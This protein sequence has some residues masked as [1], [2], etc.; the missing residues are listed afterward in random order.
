[1]CM[2]WLL[3]ILNF[4]KFRVPE[5][6]SGIHFRNNSLPVNRSSMMC[7]VKIYAYEFWSGI[8]LLFV[9]NVAFCKY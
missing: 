7:N 5:D 8:L 6:R 2:S 4:F 3:L 9:N 1:M